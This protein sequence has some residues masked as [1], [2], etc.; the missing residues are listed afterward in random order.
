MPGVTAVKIPEAGS[1]R[2]WFS[3]VS[4]SSRWYVTKF[5]ASVAQVFG[6]VEAAKTGITVHDDMS[7][8][9]DHQDPEKFELNLSQRVRKLK[10]HKA[11]VKLVTKNTY[12][13]A[14]EKSAELQVGW[15]NFERMD[16]VSYLWRSG[17]RSKIVEWHFVKA[18]ERFHQVMAVNLHGQ[19][20]ASLASF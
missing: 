4:N 16:C 12:K 14:L 17:W 19:L 18:V 11:K 1:N 9:K 10:W 5:P 3:S 7:I 20:L 15:E 2:P 13:I 6:S 8:Y